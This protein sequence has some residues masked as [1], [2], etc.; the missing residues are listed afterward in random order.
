M[1][2]RIVSRSQ[3]GLDDVEDKIGKFRLKFLEALDFSGG[4]PSGIP[5]RPFLGG[6]GCGVLGVIMGL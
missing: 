5:S 2:W 4:S 6:V 1:I 3:E